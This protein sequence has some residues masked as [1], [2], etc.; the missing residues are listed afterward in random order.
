MSRVGTRAL[1]V[2][3][4][5]ISAALSIRLFVGLATDIVSI[6]IMAGL[7]I[8]LDNGK[9]IATQ[10]ARAQQGIP[11]TIL[12]TVLVALSLAASAGSSL[13]VIEGRR[14]LYVEARSVS[15]R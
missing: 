1:Q 10:S 13:L 12:A 4:L 5:A 3:A 6:V 14:E 2:L 11:Q 9:V 7:A 8:C 15:V